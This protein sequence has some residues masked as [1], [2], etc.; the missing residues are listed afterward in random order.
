MRHDKN[1]RLM[2]AILA[3]A[4][5]LGFTSISRAVTYVWQPLNAGSISGSWATSTNWTPN[6][7]ATGASP[8]DTADFSELNF[9]A[10]SV[11]T[12]DAEQTIGNITFGNQNSSSTPAGVTINASST[13]VSNATDIL[14]LNNSGAYEIL[15]VLGN[16]TATINAVISDGNAAT[17]ATTLAKSGS[18]TL[19]LTG[20]NTQ[21]TGEMAIN[22]GTLELDFSAP[23]SP[24]VN[25]IGDSSTPN[26]TTNATNMQFQGGNLVIK[27]SPGATNSQ[28]FSGGSA[29]AVGDTHIILVQNGA[30]SLSLN[31]GALTRTGDGPTGGDGTTADITLPTSGTVSVTSAPFPGA[32]G[33]LTDNNGAA[34]V[35]VNGESDWAAI[36]G[37]NDIVPG[38]TVPGFY[39]PASSSSGLSGN[40]DVVSNVATSGSNSADSVRFNDSSAGH[41]VDLGGGSLLTG[42]ILVTPSA[43]G[44]EVIQNGSVTAIGTEIAQSDLVVFEGNA[45]KSLT[46][47]AAIVDGPAGS[48]DLTKSGPGTLI[49]GGDNTYTGQTYINGG[50][51]QISG[52]AGTL[53]SNFEIAPSYGGNGTL[54]VSPGAV[55]DE[56]RM[57]IGGNSANFSGGNATVTQTGGT[58]NSNQWFTVGSFGAG[59][60]NMSGG[61]LNQNIAGGTQFEVAVFGAASAIVNVSGTAQINIENNANMGFGTQTTTGNGT[62][63]QTGGTIAFY[64]DGGVTLGG[65]GQVLVGSGGSGT[66][67]YNLNGGT[68]ETPSITHGS[69]TGILNF[70]GGNLVAEAASSGF[71][72]GFNQANVGAA[73]ANINTNGFNVTVPQSFSH[74]PSL[75]TTVD[76]G[77]NKTGGGTMILAGTSTYTGPTTIAG[78]TIQLAPP[79]P[80]VITPVGQYT[81]DNILDTNSNPVTTLGPLANGDTVVNGGSGGAAMNGTVTGSGISLV[82]GKY[83]NAISFDG[84]GS[85]VNIASPIIDDG[86]SSSW[87]ISLWVN[88]TQQGGTLFSKGGLNSWALS[89]SIFYLA[90]PTGAG[91]GSFPSAVRFAGAWVT[92]STSVTDGTWHMLTYV[93]S[94]GTKSIYVD[95][96]NSPL[97]QSG[98]TLADVSSEVQLGFSTDTFAGDGALNLNGALDE[99]NFFNSALSATE[100]ASLMADKTIV[101]GGAIPQFLPATSAVNLTASGTTFD[102]NGQSQLIGSLA[103]VSGSALLIG[104][105]TATLGGNNTSSVFAGNISGAGTLVKNGTG[106]QTLSGVDTYTGTTT[107]NA[108][109]L[110]FGSASSIGGT[111]ASVTVN[112]GGAVGFLGGITTPAFLATINTTSAG[113]FALT[114]ADATEALNFTTGALSPFR[115]M[116]IGAAGSVTYSGVYTPGT[117]LLRLGGGGGTLTYTPAITGSSSVQIGNTGATG[118]VVLSGAD[119]YTGTT[120]VYSGSVL[121]LAPGS[122]DQTASLTVQSGASVDVTN[123]TLV[124]HYGTGFGAVDPVA[125]IRGY[126]VSGFNASGPGPKWTGTGINSSLAAANPGVFSVGYAD[127]KNATDVANTGVPAGEVEVKYTVAGDA[128][129][130]GGV[131]LS[132]LVIVASDF[133][134]TGDDWAEGDVNY[135]GNV[136]LSDLVIV[137]SNFGSSVSSV[138]GFSSS[139]QSEWKLAEAEVHGADVAVPEPGVLSLAVVGA[140]SLLARRRRRQ[141]H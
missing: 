97:D 141:E 8:A 71:I 107:I 108:G 99:V 115:N 3:T 51:I 28:T 132:D 63:T 133:G 116:A 49:L 113:A 15:N 10:P 42:G 138:T 95:G 80:A 106:A 137:A 129:L 6:L 123:G 84:T 59:T 77:L 96:V 57:I 109:S 105:A 18:G 1:S 112:S 12:L 94:F 20:A 46:I 26:V 62:L 21:L 83:G 61:V 9:T 139:F 24:A 16:E 104:G 45:T 76:G 39:T 64:S 23:T 119:K 33:L 65:T 13:S 32:G 127:G 2:A 90:G 54:V 55:V 31:L 120:T 89:N 58:I 60:F 135:D 111:G 73:G 98:F 69:G 87:T 11:V 48:T 117:T 124:I 92:G 134:Q 53:T 41:T 101:G 91:S 47:N 79:P 102:L 125:T 82:A 19:V 5:G 122:S 44:P 130:S 136:D 50:T 56:Q 85:S 110:V 118:T 35:T 7:P 68:L 36:N 140:T 70:N 88:T 75:G 38:S 81:F 93:D 14:Y 86:S 4:G 17:T 103:G 43:G 29:I 100:I 52:T 66:Y 25:I 126:L 74:S 78:G 40:A 131:D 121:Q 22:N 72:A 27:G 30:A 37:S 67:T 114:S 34:F 128:N